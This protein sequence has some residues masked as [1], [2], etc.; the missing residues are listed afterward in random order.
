MKPL[1]SE[2][3]KTRMA[4]I[5]SDRLLA[6]SLRKEMTIGRD[7][8]MLCN[9]MAEFS[10]VKAQLTEVKAEVERLKM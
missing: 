6:K 4:K 7:L 9:Q 8:E 10:E 1:K 3:S 5:K 2:S